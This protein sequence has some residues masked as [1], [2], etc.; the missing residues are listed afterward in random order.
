VGCEGGVRDGGEQR[1]GYKVEGGVQRRRGAEREGGGLKNIRT[2]II[3]RKIMKGS[4]Q[5]GPK[6]RVI[7]E[8]SQI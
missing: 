7:T 1:G 6:K 8:R 5:K 4:Y 2:K 3:C